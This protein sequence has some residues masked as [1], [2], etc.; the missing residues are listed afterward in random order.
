MKKKIEIC[1]I[2]PARSGSKE[3]KNKNIIKFN[4]KPSL[5]YSIQ[6]AKLSKYINKTIFSSDSKHYLDIASKYKPDV[7]HL[8]SKLNSRSM[9]T[10][11]DFLLEIYQYLKKNF[12]YTPEVFAL[13]R[14]NNPTKSLKDV[15][16]A[17]KIFLKNYKK[18][19]SL[20]S[21]SLM[22]ETSYKTFYIKK[23]M[24]YSVMTNKSKI[25]SFNEP[26]EKFS[27]TFA[28]NGCIDLIKTK[29]LEEKILYGDRCYSFIPEH[30]CVDIDYKDDITF[31]NYV[32]KNFSHYVK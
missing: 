25:D 26:K 14:A 27:N 5:Y 20:R 24:L 23:N 32:L 12:N 1:A 9:S 7:L 17:I 28:G 21:V 29:N 2:I 10:D 18:F 4:G 11:R 22:N 30:P 15:N 8:R 31:A 3:I 13:L 6:V 16:N 19:S